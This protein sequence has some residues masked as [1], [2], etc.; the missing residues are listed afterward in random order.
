[1][2]DMYESSKLVVCFFLF[3]RVF[4]GVLMWLWDDFDCVDSTVGEHCWHAL[5]TMRRE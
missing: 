4:L 2:V 3:G 1:M 5:G